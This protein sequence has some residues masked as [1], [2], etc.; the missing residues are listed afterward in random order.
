MKREWKYF[1]RLL[2]MRNLVRVFLFLGLFLLSSTLPL[3]GQQSAPA[4]NSSQGFRISGTVVNANT[5]QPLNQAQITVMNVQRPGIGQSGITDPDGEFH[6]D[7][8]P[9]GKYMLIG[10]RAGFSRQ[11]YDEHAEFSTAI[12]VGPELESEGLLFQLRPDAAIEGRVTDEAGESVRYA[13]VTLYREGN[14]EGEDQISQVSSAS[15]DDQG[16][17]LFGHLHAGTYFVVVSVQPWYAEPPRARYHYTNDEK[18]TMKL[19]A[20]DEEQTG[21]SPLDVAYP[22]TY[23]AGVTDG[24]EATPLTVKAGDRVE[25]DVALSPVPAV[26]LRIQTGGEN[27]GASL[28]ETVFGRF[29]IQVPGASFSNMAGQVE[30]SGAAPGN[31]VLNMNSFGKTTRRWSQ[32]VDLA[33]DST[34]GA[35]ASPAT[36]SVDG[37]VA[38]DGQPAPASAFVQL[39]DRANNNF[40]NA[41]TSARGDF[42]IEG[43]VTKP[44]T[45]EVYVRNVPGAVVTG[46]LA[47]GEPMSKGTV[48]LRP[49]DSLRLAISMSSALG[50]VNGTSE[51]KGKA[52]AG[53]MIVLVPEN[54]EENVA[55]F[56]RDQSDSDGSFTLRAI[57]PGKYTLLAIANDWDL[58]WNKASVLKPYMKQGQTL[59]VSPKGKYRVKVEIQ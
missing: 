19:V 49:G 24:S 8:L 55:L 22:V 53:A 51:L 25:A 29:N 36:A 56:R 31:Y 34:V 28:S 32:S 33:Q 30:I 40:L 58:E 10:E 14:E 37:V 46:V 6:F 5:G 7:K 1:Y 48:T 42:H 45:Y 44:G 3:M 39:F 4:K 12:A 17:Y 23:Y 13:Q 11:S 26:H 57:V 59:E 43:A 20:N 16:H 47:G 41:Q 18:G 38:V 15:T 27:I 2:V 35:S 9:A 52:K 54:P 21:Q 50:Q